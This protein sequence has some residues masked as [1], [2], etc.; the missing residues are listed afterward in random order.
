MGSEH[1]GSKVFIWASLGKSFKNL[2]LKNQHQQG[3]H[4]LSKTPVGHD[5]NAII[6]FKKQQK[7]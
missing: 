4:D 5:D 6:F 2:L 1:L 3:S 7:I